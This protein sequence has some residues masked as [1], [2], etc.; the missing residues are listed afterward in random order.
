MMHRVDRQLLE[1]PKSCFRLSLQG[2]GVSRFRSQGA[3][4][5]GANR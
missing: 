2:Y 3:T 5:V 4:S 1:H